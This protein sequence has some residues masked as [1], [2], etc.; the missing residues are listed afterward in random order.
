MPPGICF[1]PLFLLLF[2][3]CVMC[4]LIEL[5]EHVCVRLAIKV[6]CELMI[7]FFNVLSAFCLFNDDRIFRANSFAKGA[8]T[9]NPGAV[10]Q[11]LA[12]FG[13]CLHECI[14]FHALRESDARFRTL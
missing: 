2:F 6:V 10:L 13:K 4:R 8:P 3:I 7:V 14:L 12:S 5:T 11:R 9:V 1:I